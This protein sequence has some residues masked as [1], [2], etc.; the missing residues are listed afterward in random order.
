MF[1]RS[2]F[3]ALFL[4]HG[5]PDLCLHESPARSFLSTLGKQLG[6][7]RSILMISAH[8]HTSQA[9]I[10][11][12]KQPQTIHDFVGFDRRLNSIKYRARGAP[13][14]AE[15]VK[16]LLLDA[17]IESSLNQNRGLDHGAWIPLMM[18]YPDADVPVAQLSIQPH[19]SPE[20]HFRLGEALKTLRNSQVLIIASGSATHNLRELSR[21]A[22][23][24]IPPEWVKEFS[25][26]LSKAVCEG[27]KSALFNY[28]RLAPYAEKN[29]PTAEH[30]LPLFVAMGAGDN[31]IELHSSYTYGVLSMAAY[32]FD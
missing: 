7:P 10:G 31:A 25:D 15:Q 5:A 28:R 19:L 6:K 22:I 1:S 18:M 24:A 8:W 23:N 20:Y 12:A 13:D 16:Q 17:E 26:W 32:A 21:E 9:T 4:S 29:H 11:S 14:L 3:P 27:N 2:K 30:F